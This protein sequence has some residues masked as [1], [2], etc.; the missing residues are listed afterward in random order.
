MTSGPGRGL[1]RHLSLW[2]SI[3]LVLLMGLLGVV[4]GERASTVARDAHRADRLLLQQTL[5]ELT[6]GAALVMA[7]EL[8]SQLATMGEW[9]PAETTTGERLGTL[10]EQTLAFDAGAVLLDATGQPVGAQLLVDGPPSPVDDGWAPLRAAVER[11]NG[12][13]PL[14]GVLTTGPEPM[15]AMGLPVPLAGGGRGL[16]VAL[17]TVAGSELQKYTSGL[18]YGDTY[19]GYVVDGA[20]LVLATTHP[21][22][23]GTQVPSRAVR[24]A[25]ASQRP[26]AVV[27]AEEGG[28]QQVVVYA[29]VGQTGWTGLS[30]QSASE[31]EGAQIRSGRLVQV[32]V[33]ALLLISGAA[34]VIMHRKREMALESVA[35]RDELTG[36]YNRRGWLALAEH[37]LDRAR[38]QGSARVLLFV[39]LDGLKQVNDALGHREGDRA[40]SAAAEVLLAASRSTDLVGRLG[41]DEFV[42]L[43]GDQDD[44]DG[45]RVRLLDA[46]AAWN[47][48]S[49]ADFELRLSVGAEAWFPDAALTLEELVRRA[50]AEMYAEKTR[51]PHRS[52]GIVRSARERAADATVPSA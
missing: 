40:I 6:N 23:L 34:L 50:D 45:A 14:C 18:A 33:V 12:E 47:G 49:G 8:Q 48:G 16:V 38:R 7:S 51:R 4:A 3:G 1:G 15:L 32:A 17:W 46:L 25:I 27:D 36:L 26:A 37:E 41:G 31:F 42:L 52:A 39:D 20:G 29:G 35:L 13:L 28:Q 22:L 44:A 24:S 19:R 11:D 21:E 10:L 30:T 9:D 5:S 2:V 43:L